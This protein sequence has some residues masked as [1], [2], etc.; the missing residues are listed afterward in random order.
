MPAGWPQNSKRIFPQISTSA[1]SLF[2]SG[3]SVLENNSPENVGKFAE[4]IR[5]RVLFQQ[6]QK[7]TL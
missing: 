3:D 5:S 1:W 2:R 6:K 7:P 4:N